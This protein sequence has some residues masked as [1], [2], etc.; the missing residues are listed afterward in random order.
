MQA[1]QAHTGHV[2]QIKIDEHVCRF[3]VC[4]LQYVVQADRVRCCQSSRPGPDLMGPRLR[5]GQ[6]WRPPLSDAWLVERAS[7]PAKGLEAK[8]A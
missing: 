7:A 2:S 8:L 4:G 5:E 3:P 1:V 6:N